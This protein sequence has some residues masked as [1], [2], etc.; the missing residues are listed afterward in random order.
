[1]VSHKE[2]RGLPMRLEPAR[3]MTLAWFRHVSF[4]AQCGA[5]IG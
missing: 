5:A 3:R 2:L 4:E 1:M